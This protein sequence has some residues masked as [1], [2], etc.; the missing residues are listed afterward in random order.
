[1]RVV[2]V[3]SRPGCHLCEVLAEELMPLVRGIA[4][5]EVHDIDSRQDW[6]ERYGDRIPVVE[7]SGEYVCHYRL[8]T[9][10]LLSRLRQPEALEPD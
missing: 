6:R 7:I 8:D 5:I 1:M 9:E 10:A 2:D 4:R 3:Y